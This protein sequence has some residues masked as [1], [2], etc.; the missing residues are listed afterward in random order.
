MR[1]PLAKMAAGK[2]AVR[3]FRSGFVLLTR[4]DALHNEMQRPAVFYT[5]GLPIQGKSSSNVL[6]GALVAERA[7][8]IFAS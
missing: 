6:N 5:K 8:P 3:N 4:D 1:D 2:D 7:S